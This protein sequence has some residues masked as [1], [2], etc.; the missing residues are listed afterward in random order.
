MNLTQRQLLHLHNR[1]EFFVHSYCISTSSNAEKAV[2]S[3]FNKQKNI[4]ITIELPKWNFE[5]HKNLS[6]SAKAELHKTWRKQS[7]HLSYL[8]INQMCEDDKSFT[9]KMTL[10]W[11]GHFA[12]RT[13]DN[14]YLSSEMITILRENALGNFK[15]ILTKVSKSAA[16]IKYLHLKQ[17]KKGQPNEDF[18]R[19]LCELFTL[20]RDVDYTEKDITEIARAFSGWQSDKEGNHFVNERQFDD[21]EKTIFGKTGNFNGMDVLEMIL[22]NRNTAKFIVSKIYKFFVEET[23]NSIHIEELTEV[24]YKSE[25]DISI[26]M[27]HLFTQEWFYASE[28]KL[29]KSP[30]D[31]MVGLGKMFDLNFKDEKSV[32]IAQHY[33]GQVLLDPPNVAGWSGGRQWIDSSR[34]AFRLRLGS[35]IIN[36][37]YIQ[38]ELSPE[39]DQMISKAQKKKEF[40]FFEEINWNQFW[41]KNKNLTPYDL[42]IRT[43]NEQLKSE[44]TTPEIKSV[45]QLISTPDFQLT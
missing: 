23:L 37:G 28:G 13:I 11:H 36:K 12:C 20:G 42:I 27:K 19:E 35:L 45:L 17:N 26:L 16:M 3:I 32:F 39:L 41:K 18:A 21:G 33:L 7:A 44:Y 40:S 5:N 22:E 8:W 31:L 43:N 10:F 24:F 2:D 34:L 15:D 14:P 4:N 38:D 9:E 30:I 1:T 6:K 25:Y 29:V